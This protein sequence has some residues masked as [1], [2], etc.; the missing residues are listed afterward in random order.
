MKGLL[1]SVLSDVYRDFRPTHHSALQK[2]FLKR[3]FSCMCSD[4]FAICNIGLGIFISFI[5]L[6]KQSNRHRK[7]C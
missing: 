2:K 4:M 7:S 1:R 3:L 5:A 6:L